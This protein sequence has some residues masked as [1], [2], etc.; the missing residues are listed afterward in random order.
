MKKLQRQ[1]TGNG[2]TPEEFQKLLIAT[3]DLPFIRETRAKTDYMLDVMETALNLHIQEPVVVNALNYFQK[4]HN[5]PPVHSYQPQC[6][7]THA[8]L[9]RALS[10]FPDTKEGNKQASQY[11][12]GNYHWTR[13]E[14][15]RR[16]L[17]FLTSINVTDQPSLHAWAR[18]ADFERDF[19]GKVKGLGI[20][21]FHWLLLRCG[22]PTLKPDIWVINFAKRVVGGRKI[23]EQKLVQA[24]HEIA[25]LIG[26]SLETIDLT[27]WYYE[28]LA[29][30]TMDVPQLRIVWWHMIHQQLSQKLLASAGHAAWQVEL[31]DKEKLRYCDAGITIK[32]CT[33]FGSS[34]ANAPV[35]MTL[36]Q[37]SWHKGLE[38]E[39]VVACEAPLPQ[40]AF[41]R[42][43]A[44]VVK[45]RLEWVV[46]NEPSLAI[47]I[48]EGINLKYGP[49]TNLA[50]LS[51]MAKVIAQTVM[52][53]I[54]ELET[55]DSEYPV[56]QSTCPPE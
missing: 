23:S 52:L 55:F 19:K 27:I 26:E 16:F 39:L 34:A 32:N 43:I 49:A 28:R 24:F 22:V 8:D 3:A 37:C 7:H 2:V 6:I 46:I 42:I 25:P 13:V 41:D 36:H 33:L 14:L 50:E 40:A 11:L 38:L 17:D 35:T 29:M 31:D 9:Q 53:E 18:K 15:L 51:E 48:R 30:A 45:D 56:N 10:G 44:M 54:G 47:T 20:A 21:V 5:Q 12:W 4:H 1:P